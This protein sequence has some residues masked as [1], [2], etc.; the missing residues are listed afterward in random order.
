MAWMF[1]GTY[2][3][4]V[5][6]KNGLAGGASGA[7]IDQG[8]CH[9]GSSANTSIIGTSIRQYNLYAM[10]PKEAD[11]PM[12]KTL[13]TQNNEI[14]ADKTYYTSGDSGALFSDGSN[15]WFCSVGW[16]KFGN[17]VAWPIGNVMREYFQ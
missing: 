12:V 10:L 15:N 11:F 9:L 14:R 2:C 4:K 17:K 13:G 3:D 8:D 16:N 7:E 6:G 1:Q 5:I